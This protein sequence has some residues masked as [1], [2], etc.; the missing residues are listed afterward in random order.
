MR[1]SGAW[2]FYLSLS[3]LFLS[4]HAF[5]SPIPPEAIVEGARI[6][7]V[8]ISPDGRYLA[9]V[10]RQKGTA[11]VMV[12]D[13][14]SAGA[15]KP[16]YAP[17][18]S[19][20][21]LPR[22]CH[23]AKAARLICRLSQFAPMGLM[24]YPVDLKM[25]AVNPDGTHLLLLLQQKSPT[26]WLSLPRV[27]SWQRDN[28]TEVLISH[29]SFFYGPF[30]GSRITSN[31][32]YLSRLDIETDKVHW[33][34]AQLPQ[35][36][37]DSFVSDGHGDAI[38]ATGVEDVLV[39][40]AW[41]A[42]ARVS[43]SAPWIRLTR[44]AR[45]FDDMRFE[46]VAL[47]DGTTDAFMLMDH[48]GHTALWRVDLSDTRDPVPE[49]WHEG[50]N[51]DDVLRE[52]DGAVLGVRLATT[53]AGPLYLNDRSRKLDALLRSKW[54]GRRNDFI[55]AT[56]NLG[57]VVVRTWGEAEIPAYYV[58]SGDGENFKLELVGS[59][60]PE[61]A[62]FPLAPTRSMRVPTEG[63]RQIYAQLTLPAAPDEKKPP[64][65]VVVASNWNEDALLFDP[66]AQLLAS[67]GYAVLRTRA[68]SSSADQGP[69]LAPLIDWDGQVY[70]DM[71]TVIRSVAAGKDVDGTRSCLVGAGYGGYVA[72]L[73]NL[74]GD[75]KPACAIGIN[76]I[77]D[78]ARARIDTSGST[79]RKVI[80]KPRTANQPP[81]YSI[82]K[83]A[84]SAHGT[85]L[86]ISNTWLKD[87]QTYATAL[88]KTKKP[89]SLV[90]TELAGDAFVAQV[91]TEIS[92]FLDENLPIA[93][94]AE[95]ARAELR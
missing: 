89:L 65:L 92:E 34:G 32:A 30:D 82:R 66:L 1:S 80:E 87:A 72:M 74:R 53:A 37:Y 41:T 71:L 36:R 91:N 25:I 90:S 46:P 26:V 33:L 43:K 69:G 48:N 51:V 73:G 47:V 19:L 79:A 55:D 27:A 3:C 68:E 84:G 50:L 58:L 18:Q 86:L 94:I 40:K 45:H 20:K 42:A 24:E 52:G 62:K 7:D 57:E 13:R 76:A 49:L 61:M 8:S 12:K 59:A 14:Q 6:Q 17:T 4:G 39:P 95:G 21:F 10:T 15:A 29:N 64:P 9:I 35:G 22:N 54:P 38:L 23:W 93:T 88:R 67:R 75:L 78:L 83:N 31:G 5:A 81:P 11:I 56:V 60:A 70:A 2:I 16:V 28:P 77:T 63:G 44:L 85:T